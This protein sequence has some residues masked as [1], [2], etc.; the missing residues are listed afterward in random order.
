MGSTAGQMGSGKG[1]FFPKKSGFSSG[2]AKK[3][4]GIL[5]KGFSGKTSSDMIKGP[6]DAKGT[7]ESGMNG[8]Y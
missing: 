4:T 3:K 1:G 8:G 2:F 6:R 5:S 7:R